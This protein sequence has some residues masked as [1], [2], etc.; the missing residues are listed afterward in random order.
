MS[1]E[2]RRRTS[3]IQRRQPSLRN[4]I[5]I[6]LILTPLLFSAVQEKALAQ[7]V[8]T[9]QPPEPENALPKRPL[10]RKVIRKKP[11]PAPA[12]YGHWH[13]S[14][15]YSAASKLVYGGNVNFSVPTRFVVTNQT[16][17]EFG[18]SGGYIYT[19]PWAF[20]F[21]TDLMAELPRGSQ[22]ISGTAG[23]LQVTG[24]LDGNPTISLITVNAS[25]N[26]SFG[27]R[28]Y[29]YAGINVPF[30]VSSDPSSQFSGL[31]GYQAGLGYIISDSFRAEAGYRLSAM[32]GQISSNGINFTVTEADFAGALFLL[33][34]CF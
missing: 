29:L 26:F 19:R 16:T 27:E 5:F 23:N 31:I 11:P 34:Y 14:L 28:L 21:S 6:I 7:D 17:P 30:V 2:L 4:F 33:R 15:V 32:T 25:G 22:G 20:G 9:P 24:T 18:L 13:A 1:L 12:K 8:S 10:V 3:K